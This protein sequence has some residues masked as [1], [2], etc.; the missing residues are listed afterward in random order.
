[1]SYQTKLPFVKRFAESA[2]AGDGAVN[3]QA[4]TSRTG[5][6]S[7]PKGKSHSSDRP[8]GGQRARLKEIAD[9][10]LE[11]IERGSLSFDGTLLDLDAKI[12]F[13]NHNTRYYPP[14]ASSLSSWASNAPTAKPNRRSGPEISILEVSTLDGTRLLHDSLSSRSASH[15]RI[16][17]LNFASATRPG[18]GFLDGAQAQ[19]E[20]IARSSTLYPSLM[21]ETA[22]RF[23]KL[24]GK[25]RNGGFY[26]HA[27]IYSPAVVILRTDAGD[28]SSPFEV[29]V[30]TSAAVNAGDVRNK[31]AK[32][33]DPVDDQRL[34][35]QIVAV[36]RERMARILFLFEQQGA[37][38]IVLGSFGTGVFK[39][40][41]EV[42]SRIWAELLT[43]SEARYKNTFDRV[44]F[45]IVGNKT[46]STFKSVFEGLSDISRNDSMR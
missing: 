12:R 19:E 31:N 18:G 46:Y 33:E 3:G 7:E 17:L 2:A 38:N 25:D 41:V 27:M 30:L 24:H 1:M 35:K 15:G 37:T 20:S 6:I 23:Y 26:H 13:S 45:A 4:A 5:E 34:E 43:G 39:N 22:Q 36:M 28:W 9:S 16:A 32:R 29:D 10:T 11:V 21:T 42:V 8:N 40:D 44:V 14:D